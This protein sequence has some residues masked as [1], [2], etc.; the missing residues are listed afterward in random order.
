MGIKWSVIKNS[1][2]FLNNLFFHHTESL[3]KHQGIVDLIGQ[4]S[5]KEV[6][7]VGGDFQ[8][9]QHPYKRFDNSKK[10]GEWLKAAAP[11]NAYM[12]IK[13]SRSTKM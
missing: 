6:V 13:G 9:L 7:L 2:S 5:W 8:K 10:A 12:L 4:Y 1:R 3:A 11:K